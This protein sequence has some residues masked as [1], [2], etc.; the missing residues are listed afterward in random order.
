MDYKN[1]YYRIVKYIG[2]KEQNM[3]RFD[4]FW[5]RNNKHFTDD[6]CKR[7]INGLIKGDNILDT[8]WNSISKDKIDFDF[9]S[10]EELDIK[11]TLRGF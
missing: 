9:S 11:L 2:N 8:G 1:L 3:K 7:V 4:M 10:V 5:E 6:W